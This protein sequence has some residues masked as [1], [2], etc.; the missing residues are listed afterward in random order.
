MLC[1]VCQ[2]QL[3]L[4][5]NSKSFICKKENK[6][7]CYDI[8][9]AGYVN[10]ALGHAGGGDSKECVK[11]RSEFLGSGHYKPI[12]DKIN[13]LAL[14]YIKKNT[15]VL[16]AGCGEGYYTLSLAKALSDQISETATVVGIDLSKY[17]IEQAAK[18]AKRSEVK[19]LIYAVSSIYELPLPDSSLGGIVSLFAPCPA[20]E[21]HRVLKN[22][23]ILIVASAGEKHLMGLKKV[24]YDNV[25]TNETRAD[26]PSEELFELIDTHSVSYKIEL[27][28]N[29]EITD[30]FAMTPYF[31]RTS[32]SDKQ[33]LEEIEQLITEIEVDFL[34]YRKNG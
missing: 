5:E 22:G 27:T 9:S 8:S 12:S 10:L 2:T 11:S 33:K 26:A 30:L 23:G 15:D 3:E 31:Y 24:L 28:S 19:N 34:V 4:D 32:L 25:Y 21:F 16:D 13:A 14:K 20:K 1:P 17:A 18:T 29:K 6:P 7:H